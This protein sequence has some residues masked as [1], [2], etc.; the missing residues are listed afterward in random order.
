VGSNFQDHIASYMNFELQNLAP[1]S[2]QTLNTNATFNQTSYDEY[3][4]YKTGP[5]STGQSPSLVF[6]ALKHFD[7]TFNETVSKIRSQ[8][9]SELLPERYA[10]NK[11]L[12]AGYSKQR[13]ILV[14]QFSGTNAA[15]GEITMQAWGR[16]A[17]AHNKPLSRGTITLNT[18]HPE[19]YPVV[20]W[21]TFQ[22]PVDADVMV[23][24][25]RFNRKHWASEALAKYQPVE[26]APG[27]QYQTDAEII[28]GGIES[29][30]LQPTFA[31]PAGAC[32]MMPEDL[33]GCVS[34][35]LLVYGVEKLSVID[36]SIIPLIPAT[37]L[38]ATMYAVAEKAADIIKNRS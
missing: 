20:R 11:A 9:A 27:A 28:Q 17:I 2:L 31:H 26:T 15:V 1:V 18:T 22:N 5:Y 34:D 13:D 6:L 32:S 4:K 12:L 19:A 37:H 10:Q 8:N 35:K 30:S 14:K 3:I 33:G 23:A 16:S 38:Q 24:L 25:T 29:A 7:T 36:A 21:N